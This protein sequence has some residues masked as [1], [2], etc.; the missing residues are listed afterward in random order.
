MLKQSI[1]PCEQRAA[2]L[3]A[4]WQGRGAAP[5]YDLH[6][7][8]LL[9]ARATGPGNLTADARQGRDD[10]AT[11]VLC[12]TIARL[13]AI[14]LPPPAKVPLVPL[15]TWFAD[16]APVARAHGGHFTGALEAA[17]FLLGRPEPPVALH[18]DIHHANVLDFGP[19]GWLAIDPKGL[20]GERGFDYANL[21]CNPDIALE[22]TATPPA[23]PIAASRERFEARL[24][25]VCTLSDLPMERLLLWLA[26]WGGLSAAW[27]VLDG[28]PPGVSLLISEWAQ[29]RF[30]PGRS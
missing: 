15:E 13:H 9:L 27:F 20:L 2:A 11:R 4:W 23:P 17:T 19:Q 21:F 3:M 1:V 18:G 28:H 5:V 6:G 25:L 26:A 10:D 8:D 29:A 30:S 24:A 22:E 14:P 12:E 7:N 16:L